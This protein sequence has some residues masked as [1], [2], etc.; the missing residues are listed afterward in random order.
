MLKK[1]LNKKGFSLVE[2]IVV[3]AIMAILAAVIIPTVTNKIKDANNGSANTTASTIANDIKTEAIAIISGVPGDLVY[4]KAAATG[5][6][7]ESL[8]TT[9]PTIEGFKAD[10]VKWNEDIGKE[11]VSI[12]YTAASGEGAEATPAKVTV[13]CKVGNSDVQEYVVTIDAT[14]ATVAKTPAAAGGGD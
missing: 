11:G 6:T 9:A 10:E 3:I 13:K 14:T 8:A 7:V 2:L 5:N 12:Q 4:L 1:K